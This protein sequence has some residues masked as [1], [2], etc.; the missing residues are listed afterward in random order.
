MVRDDMILFCPF[1]RENIQPD[2]VYNFDK[3]E[4]IET[5]SLPYDYTSILHYGKNV[6][7]IFEICPGIL[8]TLSSN[9]CQK[10]N[11]I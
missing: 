4:S 5:Y 2:M 10:E 9:L 8:A 11:Y 3:D 1:D 7:I 6:R